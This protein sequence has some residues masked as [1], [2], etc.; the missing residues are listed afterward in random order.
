MDPSSLKPSLLK[1]ILVRFLSF[2]VLIFAVR[3]AFLVAIR[4][5]SCSVGDDFCLFNVRHTSSVA[6][7]SDKR[8]IHYYASV[9][10]DLI[11]YGYLSPNSKSLCIETLTGEEVQALKRIGVLDSVGIPKRASRK[12]PFKGNTFDFEFSSGLEGYRFPVELGSEICRTLKPGGFL[13][14]HLTAKDAYSFQ[15]FLDLF[16]CLRLIRSRET[17]GPDPSTKIQEI[18]MKKERQKQSSLGNNNNSELRREIIRNAEPLIEQEPLKPWIT[19]KRNIQNIKYLTSMVD[20]SFKRKY[21]YIDVG[22]RSYASSIG[23]WFKKQYPKQNKNFEIYGIEADKAF[24]EEYKAKKSVKLLP[25][26]AWIRNET[27][28]FEITR[29]PKGKSMGMQRG[30]GMGRIHPVQ[31]SASYVDDVDKI[32]GFDLAEWLKSVVGERDFVVM[33]M[34]VEGTEFHLMPRLI[35][36][37]AIYLID[38]VFLECHYDRWQKCCPGQRSPKYH[39]TYR[40]CLDLFT[41]LRARGVLP[42]DHDGACTSLAIWPQ[43]PP[44]VSSSYYDIG[45]IIMKG[46]ND[47]VASPYARQEHGTIPNISITRRKEKAASIKELVKLIMNDFR[48]AYA[49]FVVIRLRTSRL[50][51]GFCNNKLVQ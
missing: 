12:L 39:N 8:Y 50:D 1:N 27:L 41:S 45:M 47:R 42:F 21:V 34:D 51:D 44:S 11:A 15:S 18:V 29:D 36:T 22:A 17:D 49:G 7:Q 3:F 35:E 32:Q 25:Y 37:G 19:L 28:F 31:S 5:Q 48:M 6:V 46:P 4:G 9:F 40:Q 26:A 13:V 2:G 23:N 24:H 16:D 43:V 30:R 33:K 14:V 10:Q 20:I 38:E